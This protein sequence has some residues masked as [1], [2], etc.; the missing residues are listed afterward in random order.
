MA[1]INARLDAQ[2]IE[3]PLCSIATLYATPMFIISLMFGFPPTPTP[4]F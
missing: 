4:I 2:A 3:T 1:L